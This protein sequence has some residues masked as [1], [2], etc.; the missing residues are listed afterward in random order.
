MLPFELNQIIDKAGE[1]KTTSVKLY[2]FPTNKD[3]VA[4]IVFNFINDKNSQVLIKSGQVYSVEDLVKQFGK[5][6]LEYTFSFTGL[7]YDKDKPNE[8][9]FEHDVYLYAKHKELDIKVPI[10]HMWRADVC[11]TELS[12]QIKVGEKV[13]YNS[14]AVIHKRNVNEIHIGKS[15]LFVIDEKG[16]SKLQYT[17]SG[18]LNERIVAEKMMI[19][20]LKNKTLSICDMEI[21]LYF[22]EEEERKFNIDKMQEHIKHLIELKD[23]LDILGVREPLICTNLSE[24]DEECIRMLILAIKYNKS[25]GLKENNVM[26]MSTVSIGNLKILLH[27]KRRDNGKYVIEDYKNGNI[28][29]EGECHDLTRFPTSVYTILSADDFVKISNLDVKF[30]VGELKKINNQGHLGRVTLTLLELIKAYDMNE[31]KVFL[32]E[33]INLAMWLVETEDDEVAFINL[34]QCY[35]RERGLSEEEKNKLDD[36]IE[37]NKDNHQIK[38]AAYILL[39]DSRRANSL[40]G[41]MTTEEKMV[42]EQ[43]PIYSLLA[44]TKTSKS[45][46]DIK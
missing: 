41:I 37:K 42:F 7:G 39:E 9:L 33:A 45:D 19:A 15:F 8:Y 21:P 46:Y 22:T 3:E 32:D 23:T 1:Q 17:L 26:P 4:N 34:Y 11:K 25:I 16:I 6:K 31:N 38:A 10:N 30:I 40:I 35:F 27:F 20:I 18:N 24:K 29:V 12:G 44:V 36:I 5:D 13:Y 14:Y 2:E 43:Y 28:L